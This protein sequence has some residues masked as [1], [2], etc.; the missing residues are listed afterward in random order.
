MASF[1]PSRSCGFTRIAPRSSSAAPANSLSTSVPFPS[2]R[3][4]TYS[5]ATRFIPSRNGVTSMTSAAQYKATSSS[6]STLWYR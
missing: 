1:R 6:G 3:Q 4:A 5:L 2:T